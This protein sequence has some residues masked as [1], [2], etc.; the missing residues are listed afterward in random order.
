MTM[1]LLVLGGTIFLGRHVTAEAVRRGHEV[2]V[3]HRGRHG[4]ELFP[5]VEHA[6]GDR[7]GDLAPLHGRSWDAAI[8]TSGYEPE[9]VARSSALDLGH[10]VFVSTCNVYPGWPE[11][12]VDEDT[13]VWTE[14]DDYGPKKAACERAAEAALPGRVASVR[15][16]LLCGPN[17]N[18]FRLP[19]WVRR[20]AAGGE[21]VAPGDPERPVQ[22]IDARDLAAWMLDLAE[23]RVAGAF[24]GTAPPGRTTMGEA[25]EA[26]VDATGSGARL[27]W[28]PDAVL[29]AHEVE[30][31]DELP[32]WIPMADGPG[33]WAIG[34]ERARAAGLR[35][36]PVADTIAD[37][38]AWLRDGGEA[39]LPD[40]HAEVRPRG[41]TAER[42]AE[43]LGAV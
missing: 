14:G 33:T 34:T 3:F 37:T 31:W 8:D 29:V 40:W 13:P 20:I 36:R 39:D 12:P 38:W 21:V 4:L 32:L 43:L 18:V 2:T 5:A 26:A 1:R 16:G 11:E 27:H 23:Q 25:L 35:C 42:E 17:D 24:N 6:L 41:L 7:A 15:A 10:L 19:W 30:P 22:L 9:D 28:V